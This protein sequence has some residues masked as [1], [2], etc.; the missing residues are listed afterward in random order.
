MIVP[1]LLCVR[2][3]TTLATQMCRNSH[4]R[5]TRAARSPAHQHGVEIEGLILG[6]ARQRQRPP[7]PGC[8]AANTYGCMVRRSRGAMFLAN[9]FLV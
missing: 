9:F 2:K 7:T 5:P 3:S 4:A 1:A 6:L 8:P